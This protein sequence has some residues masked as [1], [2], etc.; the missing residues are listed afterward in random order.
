VLI[1]VF[2]FIGAFR[3]GVDKRYRVSSFVQRS[4][5]GSVCCGLVES[6]AFSARLLGPSVSALAEGMKK[7]L[8]GR[9]GGLQCSSL[10]KAEGMKKNLC[11]RCAGL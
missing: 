11:G 7:N 4:P 6:R 9:C 5:T 1:A 3:L 8:C 2:G 10:G